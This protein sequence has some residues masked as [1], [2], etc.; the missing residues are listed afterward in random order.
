VRRQRVIIYGA[1]LLAWLC[2]SLW[3]YRNYRQQR[4]LIETSLEQQARSI[5]TAV[6]GGVRSHRRLGRFFEDQLRGMLEE[7]GQSEGVI[8]VSLRGDDGALILSSGGAGAEAGPDPMSSANRLAYRLVESFELDA[9]A[10][11]GGPGPRGTGGGG[12]GG[13]GGWGRGLGAKRWEDE[14]RDSGPFAHGGRFSAELVLDRAP[15]DALI[16]RVGWS[17]FSA[18]FAAGIV[19]FCIGFAWRATVDLTE[20]RGKSRVFEAESRHLR[21]L[22]QAAT[23]LAHETRNPLGLIRGWTQ[24]LAH[25]DMSES[26]RHQYSHLV[27]EECDR[28]TA[29]IN[30]F[31]A[32]ARPSRP[33]IAP[34]ALQSLVDEL[35]EIL[36]PDLESHR[37]GLDTEI[38]DPAGHLLA[39]YE[40]FRQALFNLLQ[41]ALQFSPPGE[42]IEL[43]VQPTGTERADVRVLDHGPGVAEDILE[44]LFTPYCTTRPDGTGLGLAVVRHIATAHGWTVDYHPRPGGGAIFE[45]SGIHVAQPDGYSDR[46]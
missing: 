35:A 42:R 10:A 15:A 16:R 34:V 23:G 26:Q 44:T 32:F 37:V 8:D 41:N 6:V 46:G 33:D 27:M 30:Q 1:L 17:H 9:A 28:V 2:F 31:L 12:G 45:I 36:Q 18:A 4:A 24:R 29:R 11:P 7:L 22:S 40:L 21:E 14:P 3:Q 13:G 43:L 25:A 20:A 38:P 39:D 5:L 19:A